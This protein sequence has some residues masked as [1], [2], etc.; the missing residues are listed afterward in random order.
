MVHEFNGVILEKWRITEEAFLKRSNS[1]SC[2]FTEPVSRK[3][4]LQ[5]LPFIK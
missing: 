1:L 4:S 3:I 2:P 5:Y